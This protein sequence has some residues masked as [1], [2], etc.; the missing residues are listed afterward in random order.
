MQYNQNLFV[1]N[2][3]NNVAISSNTTTVSSIVIDTKD[4]EA[5]TLAIKSETITDGSYSLLIEHATDIGLTDV[6]T[7]AATDLDALLSTVA[8]VAADDN[9]VKSIGYVGKRQFVRIS[10]VSTGVTTG[11]SFSATYILGHLRIK[12]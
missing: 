4:G 7:V 12:N 8:F 2:A 1:G 5:L 10:I 9:K 11:G 3:L 6:A